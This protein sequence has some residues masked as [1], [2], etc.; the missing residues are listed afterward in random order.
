M[1][2]FC[3]KVWALGEEVGF[4]LLGCGGV[5][6]RELVDGVDYFEFILNQNVLYTL[7]TWDQRKIVKK[8]SIFFLVIESVGN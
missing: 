5:A 7:L 8:Y 2:Y 6:M 1:G 4:Q 3:A